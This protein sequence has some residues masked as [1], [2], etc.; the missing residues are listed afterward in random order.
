MQIIALLVVS[1]VVINPEYREYI[2]DSYTGIYSP[3]IS[4]VLAI[5]AEK[6]L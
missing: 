6:I 4:T 3:E 5:L 2:H 1:R